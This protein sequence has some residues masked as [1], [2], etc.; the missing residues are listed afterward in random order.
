MRKVTKANIKAMYMMSFK[1]PLN[2]CLRVSCICT[3]EHNAA[4]T[5]IY[6]FIVD[7]LLVS[8]LIQGFQN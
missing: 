3:L 7:I 5:L 4:F 1:K 6:I 8:K 2:I